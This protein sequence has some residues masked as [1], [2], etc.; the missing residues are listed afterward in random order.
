MSTHQGVYQQSLKTSQALVQMGLFTEVKFQVIGGIIFLGFSLA[1][2]EDC[3]P[4]VPS[5]K[6]EDLVF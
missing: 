4:P 1:E 3:A 5:L 2:D 6:L